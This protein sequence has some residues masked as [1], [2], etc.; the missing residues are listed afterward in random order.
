MNQD[1]YQE[2]LKTL[3]AGTD[4]IEGAMPTTDSS[5]ERS[6]PPPYVSGEGGNCG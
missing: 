6:W 1:S 5:Q 3:I 2:T 4:V